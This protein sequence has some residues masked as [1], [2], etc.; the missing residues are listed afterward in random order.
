MDG[1]NQSVNLNYRKA[2]AEEV[3]CAQC[4]YV[5][6]RP[7]MGLRCHR[8]WYHIVIS[9]KGTCDYANRAGEDDKRDYT[10]CTMCG[11]RGEKDG[12]PCCLCSGYG[13]VRKEKT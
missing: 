3:T 7:K 12:R 9:N 8:V 13:W 1:V 11:G 5:V 6:W 2:K 4:G 10:P